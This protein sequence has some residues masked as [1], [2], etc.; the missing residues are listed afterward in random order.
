MEPA[1][2]AALALTRDPVVA[3]LPESSAPPQ[4]GALATRFA[5]LL[6]EQREQLA[7]R[8]IAE[9]APYWTAA[10]GALVVSRA[11][12]VLHLSKRET[13]KVC[14]LLGIQPIST[15]QFLARDQVPAALGQL[16]AAKGEADLPRQPTEPAGLV[17]QHARMRM[18][19]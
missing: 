17:P 11:A 1:Q 5:F 15:A 13:A 7:V 10:G 12:C 19:A 6:L 14:A 16:L 8:M 2:R 4:R 18:A 9:G 3:F